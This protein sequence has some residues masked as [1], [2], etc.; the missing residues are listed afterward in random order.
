MKIIKPPPLRLSAG[1]MPYYISSLMS[2][3][4]HSVEIA[5]IYMTD[6]NICCFYNEDLCTIPV[7]AAILC[8]QSPLL[9]EL[10][11]SLL[12]TGHTTFSVLIPDSDP[13][14]IITLR[15]LVY[16]GRYVHFNKVVIL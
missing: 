8:S 14:S 6:M 3:V 16:S 11:H 2:Y 10:Y 13:D 9:N 5:N 7:H 15:Q 1:D 12:E 4:E